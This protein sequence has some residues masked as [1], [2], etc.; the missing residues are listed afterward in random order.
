[1]LDLS[2]AMP[3]L[4]RPG[5]VT[6]E[7]I[8]LVLGPIEIAAG[9]DETAPRSPGLSLKH[10]APAATRVRLGAVRAEI[11]EAWLGFG[12]DPFAGRAAVTAMNLSERGDPRRSGR[13]SVCDVARARRSQTSR[14]RG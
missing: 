3:L 12:P 1:M 11:G 14:H 5:A 9:H 6:R 2:E 4:L 8:E 10:Y 13:Q 7:Q